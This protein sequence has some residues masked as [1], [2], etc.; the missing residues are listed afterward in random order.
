MKGQTD[1]LSPGK[2]AINR[3]L[4]VSSSKK[5]SKLSRI[6]PK[7]NSSQF[8]I[9][10]SPS[11]PDDTTFAQSL[12]AYTAKRDS[13]FL[14]S[15][16]LPTSPRVIELSPRQPSSPQRDGAELCDETGILVIKRKFGKHNIPCTIRSLETGL[17]KPSDLPSELLSNLPHAWD[18]LIVNP[19][20]EVRRGRQK[21]KRGK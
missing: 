2:A 14:Q 16:F 17:V 19:M 12:F 13:S 8:D 6:P 3:K 11:S 10:D 20:D 5:S 7:F 9:D 4:S 21:K 18:L 1:D 15:I